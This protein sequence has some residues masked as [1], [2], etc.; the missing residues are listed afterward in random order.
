MEKKRST[1]DNSMIIKFMGLGTAPGVMERAT[2]ESG[3]KT[4]CMAKVC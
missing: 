1:Q 4:K 3:S 2:R